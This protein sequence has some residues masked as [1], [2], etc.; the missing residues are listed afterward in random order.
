MPSTALVIAGMVV[1]LALPLLRHR[2]SRV[3]SV[4]AAVV[5]A[6]AMGLSRVYLGHHWFTDVCFAWLL[7][8]AWLALLIT[9]HRLFL[10]VHR[11]PPGAPP[12]APPGR[13]AAGPPRR[14]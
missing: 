4:A 11:V 12:G 9:A 2:W 10:L 14:S 1:Y 13:P 3:V 8:L 6:V 5:W 7:G